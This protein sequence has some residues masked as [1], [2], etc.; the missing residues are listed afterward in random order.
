MRNVFLGLCLGAGMLLAGTGAWGNEEGTLGRIGP[1]V[2]T[3]TLSYSVDGETHSG[4]LA[5]DT[6]ME[7]ERPLVLIVHEWWGLTDYI[8]QRT[9]QLAALGY[10]ALAVDMY[11]GGRTATHPDDAGS[12]SR[13]VMSDW[14]AAQRNLE[15][16]IAEASRVQGVDADRVAIIGYCFGGA[17][18]LNAA[19]AG[20]PLDAVVSFHGSPS[21]VVDA[22]QHFDG[23][24]I[25]QNGLADPLVEQSALQSLADTFESVDTDVTV[26][27]YPNAMHAF[28]NPYAD[29]KAREFDLP[30]AYSPAAD[31]ASWQVMLNVFN[32]AFSTGAEQSG[33]RQ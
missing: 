3:R 22:P 11:G 24:V 16:A 2:E 12:F 25:I 17:V 6:R 32:R 14:P 30:L 13:E 4:Y 27:Q 21:Q 1:D 26:V 20:M 23:R 9:E 10:V 15:T 19:L 7:G 31:A 8:R 33:S 29:A 28:T 5:R 18:A